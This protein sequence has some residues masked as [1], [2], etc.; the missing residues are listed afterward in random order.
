MQSR[1]NKNKMLDAR[2]HD[3]SKETGTNYVYNM[4]HADSGYL[5][6][7]SDDDQEYHTAQ[8]TE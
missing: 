8:N 2:V 5:T 1:I 3:M 7:D 4:Y 6:P